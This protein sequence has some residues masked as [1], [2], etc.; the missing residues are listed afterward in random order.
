VFLWNVRLTLAAIGE[1]ESSMQVAQVLA[2]LGGG[3]FASSFS[4]P[5]DIPATVNGKMGK[6]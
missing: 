6:L 2:Q 1:R 4:I 5:E 3:F